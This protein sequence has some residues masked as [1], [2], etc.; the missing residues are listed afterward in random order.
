MQLEFVE[1]EKIFNF[2]SKSLQ[3]YADFLLRRNCLWLAIISAAIVISIFT[4]LETLQMELAKLSIIAYTFTAITL[5]HV[6]L[7]L[8]TTLE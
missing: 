4:L 7:M 3:H 6:F 5:V 2:K 8:F 1:D